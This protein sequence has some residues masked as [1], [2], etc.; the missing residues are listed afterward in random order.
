MKLDNKKQYVLLFAVII[1]QTLIYSCANV[2]YPTGGEV[3]K[4]PPKVLAFTPKNKYTFIVAYI[5]LFFIGAFRNIEVG[6]DTSNYYDIYKIINNDPDG[7]EY[8][9]G[10]V[11]PGWVFLNYVCGIVFDDYRS[12]I[13][14]GMFLAITPLFIRIWKS[15]SNPF[16]VVFYY[17]TLYFYCNA[18]NI[19]RQM[20]AVSIILF[21]LEYLK[22][23]QI[24]KYIVGIICAI[25]FHYSAIICILHIFPFRKTDILSPISFSRSF[26][27]DFSLIYSDTV[28][29]VVDIRIA[30]TI[31]A[32]SIKLQFPM[33]TIN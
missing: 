8:I 2:G 32:I 3:D 9:L 14:I 31:P 26:S 15:S 1:L 25:L 5:I 21:S 18:F 11:E 23:N 29:T 33:V 7:I 24:K 4:N 19:T 30:I 10:F 22:Q 16:L 20:I 27:K 17:I 6:T 12:V 13:F 28:E